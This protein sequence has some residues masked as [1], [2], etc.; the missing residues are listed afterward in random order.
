MFKKNPKLRLVNVQWFILQ[1]QLMA[2]MGTVFFM[3]FLVAI[4]SMILSEFT[5]W[6]K[7]VERIVGFSFYSSSYFILLAILGILGITTAFIMTIWIGYP[8]GRYFKKSL[9]NIA[10]AADTLTRGKLE[11]RLHVEGRDEVSQ[12]GLQFNR[13]ADQINNQVNSL[14]RLVNEN[15]ILLQKKEEAASIEERR[16]LARELHDSVSQQL[17]AVSMTMAALP[18]LIDS[19]PEQAK[20]SFQQVELM[21]TKAQQELRALIMHLRPV[22]LDGYTLKEGTIQLLEE[23]TQKYP[24][25]QLEWNIGIKTELTPGMEDQLFRVI[26]EAISNMLRHAKATRF[27]LNIQQKKE[28]LLL[29][30]EDNGVGFTL[31]DQKMSSYGISTM[32]ERIDDLG[33]RFDLIT[34][35]STGTR[36]DIRV[37]IQVGKGE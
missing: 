23:L 29:T 26:Q 8:L 27:L 30:F 31:S 18:R 13:M 32:R 20:E 33:G 6:H 21:V 14:Q 35:P 17:F 2:T 5:P 22:T 3:L 25:L 11:Y 4:F 10:D 9:K 37:P 28:R 24:D 1:Q 15:A 16:K 7:E 34:Y 36:I 19:K 12:V